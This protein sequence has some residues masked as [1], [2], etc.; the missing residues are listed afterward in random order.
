MIVRALS[1]SEIAQHRQLSNAHPDLYYSNL[2]KRFPRYHEIARIFYPDLAYAKH[3]RL[4]LGA[5]IGDTLVGTLAVG[6]S[7]APVGTALQ[8]HQW[9]EF[10]ESFSQL[11][12]DYFNRCTASLMSTYIN[13]PPGTLT[14]HSLAV[15]SRFR[16][17]GVA[18]HLI[19]EAVNHLDR[20]ERD[21]LYV[22][23]FRIRWL[24]RLFKSC[25]FA[26]VQKSLSLS[27][28]LQYGCWGSVLM[29]Y[30]ASSE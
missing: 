26:T 22:E 19:H 2:V 8:Q 16:Y 9:D 3:Q 12:L 7:D 5:F 14:L 4:V 1:G 23:T 27:E 13:A 15:D 30:I 24:V 6:R 17:R 25:S 11:E 29:R 28:R 20:D 18:R 10:F 21:V